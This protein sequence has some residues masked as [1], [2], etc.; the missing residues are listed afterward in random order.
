MILYYKFRFTIVF[1]FLVGIATSCAI[2]TVRMSN[3]MKELPA[4][5]QFQ[6]K[7]KEFRVR[8]LL[9]EKQTHGQ[10]SINTSSGIIV[11]DLH[12]S[13][14]KNVLKQPL[15]VLCFKNGC[16]FIN[17]KKLAE[18]RI[19]IDSSSG[20]LLYGN[21]TYQGSLLCV[22]ENNNCML[23]NQL[24]LEDYVYCVL[25]SESWPGWP[26]EVNKVF[27]V[28]SRTYVLAKVLEGDSS[29]KPFH[30]RNTNIH[31][32]YNGFHSNETLKKAVDETR[33]LIV[34]YNK[35]P[36]LAMFDCCCGGII[37]AHLSGV[38]FKKSPYLAR[39]KLCEFCK[40]C[41]IYQ[42]KYE[43]DSNELEKLL[44]SKGYKVCAIQEINTKKDKAGS[45]QE[46]V[47]KS[48]QG[49]T[50]LTGKQFYA[51]TTKIKSFCY[52]IEKK[53]KKII[54][55]GQGYGHHLGLCQWGARR[56]IDHGWNYR[57][58]LNFFYRETTCM[59]LVFK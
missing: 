56:M 59:K 36:I 47:I 3:L 57:S 51:L 26:L 30:I 29:K 52:S 41:K 18:K 34:T 42:W 46:V 21:N 38:D 33:G 54:I 17:G 48:A 50:T 14:K 31:Q 20:Y 6:Q 32:T 28:A 37:P 45:V 43:L 55:S 19:R 49:I 53:L 11:T 1:L 7:A 4:Q 8:V 23:I 27:A 44:Q 15:N 13:R 22:I 12:N 39:T 25:K 35:K 10:W 24:D 2:G 5:G 58:I 9:D 16:L 40:P